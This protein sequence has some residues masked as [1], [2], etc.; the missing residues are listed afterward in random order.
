MQDKVT[1]APDDAGNIIRVS[2]N[3]SEYGYV[4]VTQENVAFTATGWVKKSVRGALIHGTVEDLKDI[5]IAKKKSLPGNIVITES[6]KPFSADD[7][8]R[9]LKIA[10]NTGV[11]C[12]SHGEPIYR[13][14]F[15]DQSGLQ[16]DTLI[17][18][19]NGEDIKE[20]Q[21]TESVAGNADKEEHGVT[22]T[23]EQLAEIKEGIDEEVEE[24]KEEEVDEEPVEET[25]EEEEKD[26][27]F[28]L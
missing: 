10:G 28:E 13:K 20:A 14:S 4:R 17:P 19:T 8:D 23:P 7:P 18:H 27:S 5:G 15:Y 3:N 6:T 25:V 2:T 22:M 21:G 9:D 16:E 1:I 24:N 11:V 12:C 26:D